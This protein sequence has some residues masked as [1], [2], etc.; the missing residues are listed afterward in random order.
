MTRHLYE[1]PE[2]QA[3]IAQI[4]ELSKVAE[5]RREACTDNF[6]RN[7]KPAGFDWLTE[8][9]RARYHELQLQIRPLSAA[10]ARERVLAKRAARLNGYPDRSSDPFY[11]QFSDPQRAFWNLPGLVEFYRD[12]PDQP[13]PTE[14]DHAA[15]AWDEAHKP[16]FP[17]VD[18]PDGRQY[19]FAPGEGEQ[20]ALF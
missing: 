2:G 14:P 4:E 12:N 1:S 6:L 17:I 3:I 5:A 7:I 19:T 9:E 18:T 16:A 10:E 15:Y 13:R 20:L 8:E 11:Q